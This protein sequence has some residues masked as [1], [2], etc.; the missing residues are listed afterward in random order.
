M[1]RV[2]AF[3]LLNITTKKLSLESEHSVK[4]F[5]TFDLFLDAL[6]SPFRITHNK[7]SFALYREISIIKHVTATICIG[8]TKVDEWE[9]SGLSPLIQSAS[10]EGGRFLSFDFLRTTVFCRGFEYGKKAISL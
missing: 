1:L 6:H 4:L 10:F 9:I 7:N 3:T 8:L 2:L 5:F